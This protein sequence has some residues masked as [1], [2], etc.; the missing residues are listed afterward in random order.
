MVN[1]PVKVLRPGDRFVW[2]DRTVTVDQIESRR[3]IR[4]TFR[5]GR[6]LHV[7]ESNGIA[8]RLHYYDDEEVEPW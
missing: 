2:C 6:Y 8:H 1:L 5:P 7:T 3:F 4:P